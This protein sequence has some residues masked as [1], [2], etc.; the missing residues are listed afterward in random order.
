M[1]R[2]PEP[3]PASR[4]EIALDADHSAVRLDD[5]ADDHEPQAGRFG[6]RSVRR[7]PD[8]SL[9]ER[10]LAA[11]EEGYV[12]DPA[13]VARIQWRTTNLRSDPE[14]RDLGEFDAILCRNVLIYF[15]HAT[16]REVVSRLTARLRSDGLLFVGVSES[17][18]RYGLDVTGEERGGAFV[19]RR[20]SP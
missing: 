19:Y 1:S 5:L 12:V 16:V 2:Q 14:V 17:L 8:P 7:V 6:K 11:N 9:L 13:L 3:E 15:A 20:T 4:A 18:L 10:Y